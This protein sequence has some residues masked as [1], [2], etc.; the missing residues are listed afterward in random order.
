MFVYPKNSQI[1]Y[2][3]VNEFY[4]RSWFKEASVIIIFLSI[5][6]I[7]SIMSLFFLTNVNY[8]YLKIHSNGPIQILEMEDTNLY[9]DNTTQNST[10]GRNS[11][12]CPGNHWGTFGISQ[13]PETKT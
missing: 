2:N 7:T 11:S 4:W 13:V 8:F 5:I 1:N 10:L 6:N 12:W 9:T 3:D